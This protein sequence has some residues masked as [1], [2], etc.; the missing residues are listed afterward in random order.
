ME[1]AYFILRTRGVG[2]TQLGSGNRGLDKS[3]PNEHII[4]RGIA[5]LR[6]GLGQA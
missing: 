3:M 6:L 5:M 4:H 1:A 2:K